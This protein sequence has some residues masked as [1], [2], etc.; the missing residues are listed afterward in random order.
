MHLQKAY[1][2]PWNKSK[3]VSG[4][5]NHR[6]LSL[7]WLW[8]PLPAWLIRQAEPHDLLKTQIWVHV[9]GICGIFCLE[10]SPIWI[11]QAFQPANCPRCHLC[12]WSNVAKWHVK[13]IIKVSS[14]CT[15]ILPTKSSSYS[16]NMAIVGAILSCRGEQGHSWNFTL[17]EVW[18]HSTPVHLFKYEAPFSTE[19]NFVHS[20]MIA[21]DQTLT[22]DWRNKYNE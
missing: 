22:T 9:Y 19:K 18:L 2:Q 21:A 14:I 6:S 12:E 5:H 8:Y 1:S 13:D 17:A 3:H 15:L 7:S 16:N 20:H 10:H 4:A 11:C